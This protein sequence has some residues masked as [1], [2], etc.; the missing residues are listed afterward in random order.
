M[1]KARLKNAVE[2]L[3]KGFKPEDIVNA[4]AVA[5]DQR[6]EQARRAMDTHS[7]H[8]LMAQA[9]DLFGHEGRIEASNQEEPS[10][11]AEG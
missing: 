8:Q 3:L 6:A 2:A 5:L 10:Y 7:Y 11:Y 1:T 4:L 9:D